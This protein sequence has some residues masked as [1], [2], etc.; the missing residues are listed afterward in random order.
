MEK[1]MSKY[2]MK[3]LSNIHLWK[4]PKKSFAG[5]TLS[6]ANWPLDK[7]GDLVMATPG[8]SFVIEKSMVGLIGLFNDFA[9]WSVRPESIYKEYR[10]AGFHD[11]RRAS[12]LFLLDLEYADIV[13]GWLGAKYKSFAAV[14]G[15]G[16]GLSGLPGIPIDIISLITVNLRAIGEYATY[17]GFN[18]SC[19]HERMFALNVLSLASSR[20]DASKYAAMAQ[21]VKIA[22]DLAQKKAWKDLERH[23]FVKAAQKIAHSL[24]IRLTKAKLAQVVPATGAVVGCGYNSYY[25]NKV[26][27]SA[28]YLYRERFL[29]EKYGER[30]FQ[31]D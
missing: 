22:K 16:T 10:S 19:Q 21:L 23:A 1:T 15:A 28:Y 24:G 12:D 29:A 8:V 13:N 30:I 3:A 6:L 18:A 5:K 11:I 25:T 20:N 26:C 14:E 2:E 31:T 4:N 17:Y 9:Q 27:N 7:A